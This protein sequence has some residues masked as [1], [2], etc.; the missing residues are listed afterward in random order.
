MPMLTIWEIGLPVAP[1][2]AP[3]PSP[4]AN[5]RMRDSTAS[6]AGMTSAPS[7]GMGRPDRLRSA[8]CRAARCSLVLTGSPANMRRRQ[9]STSAAR[10]RSTS[11]DMVSAETRFL[12]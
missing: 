9:P 4:S 8:T 3:P 10:A 5:S 6:T 7:T 11:K 2:L 12:E 1:V